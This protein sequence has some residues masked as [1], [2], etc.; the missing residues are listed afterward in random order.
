[1][2]PYFHQSLGHGQRPPAPPHGRSES[3]LFHL[4][5]LFY[6]GCGHKRR[7]ECQGALFL[8]S[9]PHGAQLVCLL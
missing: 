4:Q 2:G 5:V 6:L 8:S 1:M 9:R 3:H 7:K